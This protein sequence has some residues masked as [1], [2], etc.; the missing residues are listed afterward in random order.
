MLSCRSRTADWGFSQE[1]VS[2]LIHGIGIHSVSLGGGSIQ[3]LE[4][5]KQMAYDPQATIYFAAYIPGA[6]NRYGTI[7]SIASL[8]DGFW[9][10]F[11]QGL[12]GLGDIEEIRFYFADRIVQDNQSYLAHE[13]VFV[14][15]YLRRH[16]GQFNYISYSNRTADPGVS[17][18]ADFIAS[19]QGDNGQVLEVSS[20]DVNVF[21]GGLNSNI[22]LRIDFWDRLRQGPYQAGRISGLQGFQGG[23]L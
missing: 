9:T 22:Q 17:T 4:K 7:D 15:E 10:D 11:D 12:R 1:D 5:L 18:R 8:N 2:E 19:L 20:Y 6:D 14:I 13:N 3:N 21:A 16:I 23:S